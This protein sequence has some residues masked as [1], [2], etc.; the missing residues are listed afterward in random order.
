MNNGLA[1]NRDLQLLQFDSSSDM[2]WIYIRK[3]ASISQDMIN[4]S[5]E[6]LHS[7]DSL[8]KNV[9]DHI[10]IDEYQDINTQ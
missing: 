7:Q 1:V 2:K 3:T 8:F 10:L 4:R 5:I 6:E 9:F